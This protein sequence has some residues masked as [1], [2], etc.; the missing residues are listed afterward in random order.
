MPLFYLI[1]H[2]SY[3]TLHY[4]IRICETCNNEFN[5]RP[6]FVKKGGGKFCSWQCYQKS[7]KSTAGRF[8]KGNIP[9]S[10]GK[11]HSAKTRKKISLANKGKRVWDGFSEDQKVKIKAKISKA[12]SGHL[13][14]MWK[15]GKW[16]NEGGYILVN[17]RDHP[18]ANLGG[19]IFEHRLAM[20]K[21][22]GRL[23]EKWEIVHHKNGIKDD[24]RP[25]NLELW[26][27]AHITGIRIKD[28]LDYYE[29][30][31]LHS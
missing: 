1:V 29:K 19:Y 16:K 4:M 31:P 7:P 21:K 28:F 27:R 14:G 15:G 11:H 9:W 3:G 23:L 26:A 6:S 12:N 22:I 2:P 8:Q 24:N 13:N 10:A 30:N 5:V 20:E 17:K 25:E 18:N